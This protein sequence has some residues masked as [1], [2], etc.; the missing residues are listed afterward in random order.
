MFDVIPLSSLRA[1]EAAAR[2]KSFR[3]AASE[4]SLSPS[5]ISHAIRKLEAGMG[6][7]GRAHV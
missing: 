7:I 1:F 2:T 3:N 4:L 6:E 5:A